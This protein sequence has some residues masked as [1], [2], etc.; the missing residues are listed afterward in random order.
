MLATQSR[1]STGVRRGSQAVAQREVP[2]QAVVLGR[3]A[4]EHLR[5]TCGSRVHAEE[6]VEH[7]EGVV[8]RDVGRGPDRVEHREV[9]L[10]DETQDLGVGAETDAGGGQWGGQGGG[11]RGGGGQERAASDQ[12]IT[13]S[14]VR[15]AVRLA[16]SRST[17]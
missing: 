14:P 11:Q 2:A 6:R 15:N 4:G 13:P 7:H 1:A 3:G 16:A 9:G 10:R 12:L 17:R 5:L 8:A